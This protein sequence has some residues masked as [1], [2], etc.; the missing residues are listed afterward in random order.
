MEQGSVYFSR[1]GSISLVFW[2]PMRSSNTLVNTTRFLHFYGVGNQ[3]RQ[4]A[5][6]EVIIANCL[7]YCSSV[8]FK[9]IKDLHAFRENTLPQKA[10]EFAYSS[11]VL[12]F[13]FFGYLCKSSKF[14]FYTISS[15]ITGI[16]IISLLRQLLYVIY[17]LWKMAVKAF[18][19]YKIP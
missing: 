9:I 18:C 10:H 12:N 16:N 3:F 7:V 19:M 4:S 2:L 6:M 1:W 15:K 17:T 11:K 5:R 13:L 14:E 8:V